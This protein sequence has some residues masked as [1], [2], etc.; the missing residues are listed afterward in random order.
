MGLMAAPAYADCSC[1]LPCLHWYTCECG[2]KL[3]AHYDCP[4]CYH[5]DCS[6]YRCTNMVCNPGAPQKAVAA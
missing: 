5:V 1:D 2:L 3:M 6:Y 4:G